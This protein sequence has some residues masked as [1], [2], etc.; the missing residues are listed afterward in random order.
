MTKIVYNNCFGGFGLSEAAILRY[1]E[2][3][4]RKNTDA[5]GIVDYAIDRAD[6]ALVQVVE[7]LGEAANGRSADLRIAEL[8]AGTLYRIDEYDGFEDVMAQEDYAWSV[9][10]EDHEVLADLEGENARLR[11]ALEKLIEYFEADTHDAGAFD[12]DC[13]HCIALQLARGALLE[14]DDGSEDVMTQEDY[15]WS[16]A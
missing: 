1:A 11:A 3:T 7:E 5:K 10:P 14:T 16:V 9:A 4:G 8:P 13:P 12:A 6:P 2:I 15:E